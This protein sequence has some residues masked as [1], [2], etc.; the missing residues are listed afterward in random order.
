MKWLA[1]ACLLV[2]TQGQALSCMRPDVAGSF[3]AAESIPEPVYIL[4]GTLHFDESL[5][6][7]GVINEERNPAPVPAEFRGKGLTQSGF[8]VDFSRSLELQPLCFGPWCG[9]AVAG[10]EAIIFA[11]V[12]P[13]TLRV[14]VSPCGGNIFYDPTPQMETVLAACLRGEACVSLQSR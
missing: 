5:M 10:Q 1:A 8:S 11:T 6:P 7:Q 14:E 3:I 4:R 9:N 12:H 13:D 2:A